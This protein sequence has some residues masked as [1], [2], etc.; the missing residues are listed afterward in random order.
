MPAESRVARSVAPS[1]PTDQ[2]R[3]GTAPRPDRPRVRAA[4]ARKCRSSPA[5]GDDRLT[6]RSYLA[7][8]AS[9]SRADRS[10]YSL[11]LYLT[12]VPPYFE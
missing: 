2:H 12:S 9:T 3:R 11:P 8:L 4:G 6:G 1:A 10:R 5:T 7:T